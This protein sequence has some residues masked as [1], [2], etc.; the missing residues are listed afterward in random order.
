GGAALMSPQTIRGDR[1][2]GAV[3]TLGAGARS[4]V[5]FGKVRIS[6]SGTSPIRIHV[7]DWTRIVEVNRHLSVPG[8]L[9]SVLEAHGLRS[10]ADTGRSVLAA[11]DSRGRAIAGPISGE[12]GAAGPSGLQCPVQ[13]FT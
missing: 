10:C 4:E 5:P 9:G 13:A 3:L 8:L 7:R 12:F 1:G 6:V 11:V 2:P